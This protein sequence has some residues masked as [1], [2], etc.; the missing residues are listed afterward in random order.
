MKG[1][2]GNIYI[3]GIGVQSHWGNTPQIYWNRTIN[4]TSDVREVD[5]YE[6]VE[7]IVRGKARLSDMNKSKGALE[8]ILTLGKHSLKACIDD[9]GNDQKAQRVALI[10]GSGLGLADIPNKQTFDE[11]ILSS[12]GQ[13]IA[14][15]VK[16]PFERV[17]YIGNACCA[18]SQAIAYGMQ[19]LMLDCYD[20]VIAGGMDAFSV[21]ASAGF[22]RLHAIDYEGCK[23]FDKYRKG[24]AIGEGACFFTLEREKGVAHNYG[25]L[26]ASNTTNDAF[27]VVQMNPNGEQIKKAILGVLSRG[28]CKPEEIDL[29]VAHGTGTNINDRVESSVIK[30]I[31]N[32]YDYR[33]TSIKG[34][35]G[36]TGG[37]SGTFSL[38]TAIGAMNTGMVPAIVNLRERDP[39]CD[40]FT[41]MGR[42]E[43]YEVSTAL[44]N[45]FAF[46]GTNVCLLLQKAE[47]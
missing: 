45:A 23:P 44:I 13:I 6:T 42:A 33:V 47:V 21:D 10:V 20:V 22:I 15:S 25:V 8:R 24:I 28:K 30:E 27:H 7:A 4:M 46:G 32:G 29:I 43:K 5:Y 3:T 11:K 38:L 41:V 2:N 17:I 36:H 12:L 14:Q 18:G 1:L 40:I 31:F 19:L 9:W 39:E 16:Y 37:G 34:K 26:R 35:I